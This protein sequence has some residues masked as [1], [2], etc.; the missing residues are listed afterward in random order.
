MTTKTAPNFAC[1]TSTRSVVRWMVRNLIRW[2]L[3]LTLL[4]KIACRDVIGIFRPIKV[5]SKIFLLVASSTVFLESLV[6]S[7]KYNCGI[8]FTVAN[9]I[10]HIPAIFHC[11]GQALFRQSIGPGGHHQ[12]STAGL[13]GQSWWNWFYTIDASNDQMTTLAA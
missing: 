13:P 7:I 10:T 1:G 3:F 8:L 2:H 11:K 9:F 6:I 4:K 12:L 5:L